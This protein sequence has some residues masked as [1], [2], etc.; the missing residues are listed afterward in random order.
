MVPAGKPTETVVTN[1]AEQLAPGDV[2][3]DGGNS[4]YK[5][6]IRRAEGLSA[7]GIGLIDVGT[8][9]G[10]WG[11]SVGYCMM[12]GGDVK[13]VE[14][15]R[16]IFDTLAPPDGWIHAG[17]SGAGHFVKTIH[18]G[19]EYGLMEAYGEGFEIL[20]KSEFPLDQEPGAMKN[21]RRSRWAPARR[22]G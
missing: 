12:V 22:R 11:R 3:I 8:S 16:P 9:G 1:L 20:R 15:L 21:P 7:R 4:Y 14:R 18:N 17:P 6:T 10:I 19:I 13:K 5:D 2:V